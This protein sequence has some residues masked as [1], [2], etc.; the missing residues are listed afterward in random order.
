ME[1]RLHE[2]D[3]DDIDETQKPEA[4]SACISAN[5]ADKS[6]MHADSGHAAFMEGALYEQCCHFR[7]TRHASPF[8]KGSRLRGGHKGRHRKLP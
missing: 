3:M 2:Q 1:Y 4:P 5:E 7:R 6:D 8:G